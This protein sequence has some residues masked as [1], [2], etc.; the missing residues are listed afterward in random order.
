MESIVD[1][2]GIILDNNGI[3][4]GQQWTLF[5]TIMDSF[6][7]NNGIYCG[8]QWNLFGQQWNPFLDS[9]GIYFQQERNQL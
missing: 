8:Y 1:N 7:G 4:C 3:H 2:S 9:N 5:W 6:L